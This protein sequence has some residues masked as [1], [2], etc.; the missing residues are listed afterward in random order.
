MCQLK[1]EDKHNSV[2]QP[3]IGELNKMLFPNSIVPTEN[4]ILGLSFTWRKRIRF[5]KN[6]NKYI[7]SLT[8][9]ES[10][11]HDIKKQSIYINNKIPK[12]SIISEQEICGTPMCGVPMN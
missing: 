7:K 12:L 4:Q 2:F 3:M 6:L 1:K 10:D 8:L 5:N 9:K 11:K